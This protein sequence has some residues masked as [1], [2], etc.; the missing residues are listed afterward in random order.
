[1]ID[2]SRWFHQSPLAGTSLQPPRSR[3]T[4]ARIMQQFFILQV[5]LLSQGC[6]M[7]LEGVLSCE[8]HLR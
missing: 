1:M 3:E 6:L 8:Y 7:P 5:H 2:Q 4:E